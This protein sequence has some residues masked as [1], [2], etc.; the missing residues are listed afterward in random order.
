MGAPKLARQLMKTHGKGLPPLPPARA[1]SSQA[2]AGARATARPAPSDGAGLA[3]LLHAHPRVPRDAEGAMSARPRN[4]VL[5]IPAA[6]SRPLAAQPLAVPSADANTADLQGPLRAQLSRLRFLWEKSG[7]RQTEFEPLRQ[8]YIRAGNDDIPGP[9]FLRLVYFLTTQADAPALPTGVAGIQ[10]HA[11]Q[12]PGTRGAVP[13]LRRDDGDGFLADLRIAKSSEPGDVRAAAKSMAHQAEKSALSRASLLATFAKRKK[14]GGASNAGLTR[15]QRRTPQQRV[16]QF[17]K[18]QLAPLHKEYVETLRGKKKF[19]GAQ[20]VELM[21]QRAGQPGAS[22]PTGTEGIDRCHVR[23]PGIHRDIR[24]LMH[25][26]PNGTLTDLRLVPSAQEEPYVLDAMAV[27]QKKRITR[28]SRQVAYTPE[29]R[30]R[31]LQRRQWTHLAPTLQAQYQAHVQ[32]M[33]SQHES[34]AGISTFMRHL[35]DACKKEG[36]TVVDAQHGITRH[37]LRLEGSN[38]PVTLLRRVAS[39]DAPPTLRH[40]GPGPMDEAL[41]IGEIVRHIRTRKSRTEREAQAATPPAAAPPATHAPAPTRA[42]RRE[43][44]RAEQLTRALEV[45]VAN[46]AAGK[47]NLLEGADHAAGLTGPA[48]RSWFA[49]DG[50]LRRSLD[51]MPQALA[52]FLTERAAIHQHLSTLGHEDQAA[53]LPQLLSADLVAAALQ[54]RVEHPNATNG[55]SL[56]RLTGGNRA[57]LVLAL[58]PA[59]G[60]LRISDHRLQHL[61]GYD[62]HWQT[63][64][65]ALQALGHADR[66][67][68]LP[69]PPT[70]GEQFVRALK[71]DLYPMAAAV[72]AMQAEPGLPVREAARRVSDSAELAERLELLVAPGGQVR[73]RSEVEARLPHLKLHRHQQE[74]S[75]LLGQLEPAKPSR[76]RRVL[77]PGFF[78]AK[79]FIVNKTDDAAGVQSATKKGLPAI[80]AD[81]PD[82]VMPPRSFR[83]DRTQQALRWLSTV[84]KKEFKTTEVQCYFDAK[85]KDVWVSSNNDGE[86]RKI[87]AFLDSGGLADRLAQGLDAGAG[88]EGRHLS[89]LARKLAEPEAAGPMARVLKAMA[90]GRFQVPTETVYQHGKTID[91]HAERRIKDAFQEA[92]GEALKLRSLAGTMRPCTVCAEDLGLPRSAHRGPAWLSRAAQAFYDANEIVERNVA[93]SIGTYASLTR[94]GKLSVNYN[95]DSDSSDGGTVPASRHAGA[96]ASSSVPSTSSKVLGK[97]KVGDLR[98]QEPRAPRARV[99][100]RAVPVA[101]AAEPMTELTRHLDAWSWPAS[102]PATTWRPASPQEPT[103]PPGPEAAPEG[104]PATRPRRS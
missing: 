49:H 3:S 35:D 51:L 30:Y 72:N 76:M 33:H 90:Q 14:A 98:I 94:A 58:D 73:S 20:L 12:L 67:N 52:G 25:R 92:T 16:W 54:A 5:P 7:T 18:A 74:L 10:R 21:Q 87:K 36:G 84:L 56:A 104:S 4:A 71:E 44:T 103:S 47:S 93:Q 64:R 86:N 88:R 70:P 6:S 41:A 43:N 79:L 53:R 60:A 31:A 101:N 59:T 22:E 40:V 48:L 61:P 32:G 45:M 37:V 82:L 17:R 27:F 26:E 9:Q 11:V 57:L 97:R 19:T 77:V 55:A 96:Q 29:E 63:I 8:A 85:R 46:K 62:T 81:S 78:G 42:G 102:P 15:A 23:L 1:S 69:P 100:P 65:A 38:E 24:F 66:A 2:P 89:K 28:A 13:V 91:L 75:D 68:G 50:K 95:T 39:D 99:E 80:Y 83:H 34:Y